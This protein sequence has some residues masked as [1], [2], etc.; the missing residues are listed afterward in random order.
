M[1]FSYSW[2]KELSGT[3]LGALEVAELL[4]AKSF[5]VESVDGDVLDIKVLPNRPD[6]LS[7][8]GIARELCALEGTRLHRRPT[9]ISPKNIRRLP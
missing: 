8:L 6:C 3:A 5:E 1:K 7:H 4:T 2:I 9:N